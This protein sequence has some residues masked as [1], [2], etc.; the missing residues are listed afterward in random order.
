MR[1]SPPGRR[2]HPEGGSSEPSLLYFGDR[3]PLLDGHDDL[4]QS[5]VKVRRVDLI[6]FMRLPQLDELVFVLTELYELVSQREAVEG[7]LRDFK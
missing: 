5:G 4:R 2:T 7:G 6:A 1:Q 3:R